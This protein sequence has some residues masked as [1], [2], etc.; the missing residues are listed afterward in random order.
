M[1][2][3]ALG[4]LAFAEDLFLTPVVGK[5]MGPLNKY[6]E[7]L[8]AAA[9]A[10]VYASTADIA[11]QYFFYGSVLPMEVVLA[12]L[13]AASAQ[14]VLGGPVYWYFE[15]KYP[16]SGHYVGAGYTGGGAVFGKM[17]HDVA[18]K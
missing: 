9:A 17:L 8:P 3:L 15:N 6:H 5:A 18:T 7:S 13:G 4:A 12:S 1:D 11:V 2:A 16:G 14:I 10:S